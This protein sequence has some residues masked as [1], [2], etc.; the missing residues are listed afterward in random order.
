MNQQVRFARGVRL[1]NEDSATEVHSDY[2]AVSLGAVPKAIEAALNE[3]TTDYVDQGVVAKTLLETDGPETVQQFIVLSNRLGKAGLT[4]TRTLC[5]QAVLTGRVPLGPGPSSP[6][7]YYSP[8]SE[9]TVSPFMMVH[10]V[11]GELVAQSP[12]SHLGAVLHETGFRVLSALST[13]PTSGPALADSLGVDARVIEAILSDLLVAGCLEVHDSNE[14]ERPRSIRQWNLHDA[15]L[16]SRTRG[17]RIVKGWG[18]TYPMDGDDALPALPDTERFE[19]KLTLPEPMT[20]S[21]PLNDVM[22]QRASLRKFDDANPITKAE[23]STLLYRVARTRKIVTSADGRDHLVDRP[24]PSGGALHEIE[25]YPI[26]RLCDGIEPAVWH[27]ESAS[28]QLAKVAPLGPATDRLLQSATYATMNDDLPQV[29]IV[30]TARFGRV[31]W[32][33]ETIAYSLILKHVGVVMES[34]YLVATDI[35]VAGC[36]VGSGDAGDF[37]VASGIDFFEEGSV[38]EFVVGSRSQEPSSDV[39]ATWKQP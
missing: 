19:P 29:L 35:G 34:L 18:A 33:Y 30:L 8:T 11:D 23:L 2:V 12:H 5:D 27:Y 17:A 37:A 16:H 9:Y 25:F 3:M 36:A 7:T 31:M 1:V 10:Q 6:W 26:V 4:E 28:H 39:L 13:A 20:G 14:K 21:Q 24:Y 15:W 32:K 22:E 38:G